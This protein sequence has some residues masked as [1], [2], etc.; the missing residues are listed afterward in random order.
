MQEHQKLLHTLDNHRP[1][2]QRM[3]SIR[4][5]LSFYNPP[6]ERKKFP[7][8]GILTVDGQ[9]YRFMGKTENDWA[10]LLEL[11]KVNETE[12]SFTCHAPSAQWNTLQF[13]DTNW[14]KA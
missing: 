10:D 7:L 11:L 1:L 6:L 14:K 9:P 12:T 3:V 2:H 4:Y 5:P 8:Q 13:D